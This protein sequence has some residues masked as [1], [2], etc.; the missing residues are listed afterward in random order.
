[1]G[2]LFVAQTMT[3]VFSAFYSYDN[4]QGFWGVHFM[5][6]TVLSYMH[7]AI[8]LQHQLFKG[9]CYYYCHFTE[10]QTQRT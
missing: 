10:E 6:D 8:S 1:M 3:R 2:R 9:K 5:G 4:S 7:Y